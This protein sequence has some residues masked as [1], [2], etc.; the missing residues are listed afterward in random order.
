MERLVKIMYVHTSDGNKLIDD[1]TPLDFTY[2]Y[3]SGRELPIIAVKEFP[4]ND[5]YKVTFNDGR[6]EFYRKDE[7]ITFDDTGKAITVNDILQLIQKNNLSISDKIDSLSIG[8]KPNHP[9]N[10]YRHSLNYDTNPNILDAYLAGALLMYGD[11]S[12]EYMNIPVESSQ[13]I[14]I[15]CNKYHIENDSLDNKYITFKYKGRETP[16][17]WDEFI[18]PNMINFINMKITEIPSE[19]LMMN[20]HNRLQFIIGIFDAG[21]YIPTNKIYPIITNPLEYKL[22]ALQQIIWSIGATSTIS[23][24]M[25]SNLYQLE[26]QCPMYKVPDLFYDVFIKTQILSNQISN[27]NHHAKQK[28]VISTIEFY[29]REKSKGLITLPNN[30]LYVTGNFIPKFSVGINK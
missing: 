21:G 12:S 25:N 26:I 13:F 3:I 11:G 1:I 4:D 18:T 15:I 17:K 7:Y 22:R 24:Y 2:D 9:I 28:I 20:I 27:I 19:Y 8:F 29:N 14:D 10:N 23:K 6:D 30:P 5:I 16:I